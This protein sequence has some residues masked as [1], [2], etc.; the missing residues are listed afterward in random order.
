VG[1]ARGLLLLAII[2][3]SFVVYVIALRLLGHPAA[4]ELWRLPARVL[5]RLRPRASAK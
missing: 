1:A 2:T 4:R 5:R 3:V